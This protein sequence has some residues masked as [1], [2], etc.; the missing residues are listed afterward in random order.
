MIGGERTHHRDPTR[1][2][3][4]SGHLNPKKV[5]SLCFV[6]ATTMTKPISNLDKTIRVHIFLHLGV[7]QEDASLYILGKTA[8]MTLMT[9]PL[10]VCLMLRR[11]NYRQNKKHQQEENVQRENSR[12]VVTT[13]EYPH[14]IFAET[15]DP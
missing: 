10:F 11:I 5:V 2:F 7:W 14:S 6:H 3:C 1:A 13:L 9:P 4:T 12:L 15:V 8:T